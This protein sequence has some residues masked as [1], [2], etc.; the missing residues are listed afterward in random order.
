MQEWRQMPAVSAELLP[1]PASPCDAVRQLTA[2]IEISPPMHELI[3][4]YRIEGGIDRLRL[5]ESGTALRT[6]GLWQHS[7]FEAFLRA[8]ASDSYH[9]FN[10]APSGDWETYCF[11]SRREGRESPAMPAPQ[12]V[13]RRAADFCELN[14][15]VPLATLP[16]LAQ[17]RVLQIGLAAVIEDSDGELSYWALAHRGAK[18]DF[19]D[20]ATFT[21]RMTR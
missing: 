8:D 5:P 21:L 4:S 14:V 17:A 6:D 20:P 7:C 10:F 2:S 19:H 18:A 15:A 13:L 16:D 12:I 3:I 9:E 1:H 11:A